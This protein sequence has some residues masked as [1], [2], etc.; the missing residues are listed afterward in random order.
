MAAGSNGGDRSLIETPTWAVALVVAV[1]VVISIAIE[2]GI[3]NLGKVLFILT[4]I[5]I[6]VSLILIFERMQWFHKRQ[7]K[8]M[9]EALEKIK[10]ELMLLGFISLLLTIGQAPISSICVPAKVVNTMLPC[11]GGKGGGGGGGDDAD[12]DA[13]R[14]KLLWRR[15]LAAG[16]STTNSCP[17][18]ALFRQFF[19]SVTKV[20]YLTMRH[21]FI[22]AHLSQNNNF[23]FHKYIKRSLEDDFKV[24][25]GISPPLWVLA[26]I[27]LLLDVNGYYTLAT[28]SVVP[29]VVLLVVGT[30]LELVI[31]EMAQEIQDKTNIIIGAPLV[32]PNNKFFWFNKP[33]WILFLIHLTLFENAFQMAHFLWTWYAFKLNSCFYEKFWLTVVKVVMGVSL[34]I[35]CSYITLPLYALV[36]QMGSHMKKAIF[37]EQTAKALKKWTEAAR[38]R[39]K[40]RDA[41]VDVASGFISGDSTPGVGSS[42]VH[43]LHKFNTRSTDRQSAPPSPRSEIDDSE[44]QMKAS[45]LINL[46]EFE[47]RRPAKSMDGKMDKDEFSFD[48]PYHN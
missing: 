1:M 40:L 18:V 36:T 24:V 31:M 6:I 45:T 28:V 39:K 2:H 34:Q 19:G 43:L 41:G 16:S 20:D 25:V 46:E 48:S 9:N 44:H 10:A 5:Y 22:N 11:N 33:Q 7:K 26:T 29:L 3:H 47:S 8:A 21:G 12:N 14:R 17:D 30:K 42:P 4:C 38:K 23:N 15:V 37:E 32:Q 13:N 35:L 27:I